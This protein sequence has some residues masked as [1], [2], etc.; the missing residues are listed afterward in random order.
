MTH[1][2]RMTT[3]K[4]IEIYPVIFLILA[5]AGISM[6]FQDL[7]SPAAVEAGKIFE[8]NCSVSGCHEGQNPHMGLNL[9]KGRFQ[10][11]LIDV[12]SR[13]IPR[14]KLVDSEDPGQSYLLMK[15][16]GSEGISGRRMPANSPPLKA[17]DI[18]VIEKWVH[19]LVGSVIE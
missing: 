3:I 15:I 4:K 18:S 14:L 13:Q 11:S 1:K 9:E 2:G 19:S 16:K 17:E 6:T 7:M 8:K 10:D 5:A 12:P